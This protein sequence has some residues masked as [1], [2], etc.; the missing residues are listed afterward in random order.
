MTYG[1]LLCLSELPGTKDA[2][3]SRLA[4]RLWAGIRSRGLGSTEDYA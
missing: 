3:E 4:E 1:K 2:M